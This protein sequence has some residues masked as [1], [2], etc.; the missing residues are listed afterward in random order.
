MSSSQDTLI[1]AYTPHEGPWVRA[2]SR[3]LSL[4]KVKTW[5]LHME[6]N[7]ISDLVKEPANGNSRF[8]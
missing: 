6:D 3:K 1:G 2:I 8:T 5:I 4:R 7:I